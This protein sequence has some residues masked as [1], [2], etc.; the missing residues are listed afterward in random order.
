MKYFF[1][2]LLLLIIFNIIDKF[3]YDIIA[4]SILIL[5]LIIT[6]GAIF[7]FFFFLVK[8]NYILF[9]SLLPDGRII[10][11]YPFGY[12]NFG[13]TKRLFFYTAR[14]TGVWDE[15]GRFGNIL[16][17]C[18]LLSQEKKLLS[19]CRPIYYIGGYLS[20]SLAFYL[21]SSLLLARELI[22]KKRK[23][24][25]YVLIIAIVIYSIFHIEYFRVNVLDRLK[26]SADDMKLFSGDTR[27]MEVIRSI[28][29]FKD[30]I[31][32]GGGYEKSH[33]RYGHFAA[34]IMAILGMHGL[35]GILFVSF[36]L[37]SVIR[38][39]LKKRKYYQLLVLF[40]VIFQQPYFHFLIYSVLYIIIAK[41][42]VYAEKNVEIEYLNRNSR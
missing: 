15:P 33:E 13:F 40:L 38:V 34:N 3:N 5:N 28:K 23:A 11:Y 22:F 6:I 10:Y 37:Y 19:K 24:L 26:P 31:I 9:K 21:I 30:N 35:L 18:I 8:P 2:L 25:F 39:L 1:V 42:N 20:N 27:T 12:I 4:K 29:S 36:P 14:I 32:F 16:L 17:L 41:S 7:S